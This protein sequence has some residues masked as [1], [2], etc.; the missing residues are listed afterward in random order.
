M[1]EL[2]TGREHFFQ[3]D[4]GQRLIIKDATII[5][6]HFC[7]RTDDCALVCEAYT[8][9][10]KRVVDV[11]NILLQNDWPIR[12]YAY[13]GSYTKVEQRF[14]VVKRSKPA[15]YVYTETEV[16]SWDALENRVDNTLTAIERLGV[17]VS[18]AE[19]QR[20]TAE[21]QRIAAEE[22]R[23]AAADEMETATEE[24]QQAAT[25]AKTAVETLINNAHAPAIVAEKTA[26][27]V[28]V[29]DAAAGY[30]VG[31]KTYITATQ[32]GEGDASPENIRPIIGCDSLT[33]NRAQKN[34][35]DINA[36]D[37]VSVFDD[38]PTDKRYGIRKIYGAGK[39]TMSCKAHNSAYV[40]AKRI[41][42]DGTLGDLIYLLTPTLARSITLDL[43]ANEGILIYNASG[44]SNKEITL[45]I[46]ANAEIQIEMGETATA[47]EPPM[48]GTTITAEMPDTVY[49]GS[50][51]FATGLLTLTHIRKVLRATDISYKYGTSMAGWQTSSFVTKVDTSLAVGR[52]TS[53]SSHFKN[54]IDAAYNAASARH[55][56]F[57]DHPTI[58]TKYFAWGTPDATLTDFQNW[59]EE[60][61]T[62]GTPVMLVCQ[63]KEPQT[64]QLTPQQLE[65]LNG[66]N[67]V[68]SDTGN[69]TLSYIA[70]TKLYIDG[71]F[72]EL[73]NA[74]ISLGGNI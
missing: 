15:D 73:T 53:I 38:K 59:L 40:Y 5:E 37:L 30:A 55:G 22:A 63:L 23:K 35:L 27:V 48:S 62:A 18:S 42:A 1:F 19:T 8:D 17:E 36:V 3:W 20:E 44:D 41:K 68:W 33:I 66:Y 7:N 28:N 71:K 46:F 24:A 70:D 58:T 69:T 21:A 10:G 12:V 32:A 64:I 9:G 45:Q 25:E 26:A 74:I 6:A 57:S 65:L 34:L 51:D 13:C 52:M 56:I 16:K 72:N 47:Y 49:G 2:E 11:P 60:Q 14:E 61:Y 54:T 4:T 39:Y 50:Y 29:D 67:N 31:A 43:A